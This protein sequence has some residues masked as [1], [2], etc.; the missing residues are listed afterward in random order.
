[1]STLT[2]TNITDALNAGVYFPIPPRTPTPSP[3]D[4]SM[5]V[6]TTAFVTAAI[7]ASAVVGFP[8][9]IGSTSIAGG[10]SHSAFSGLAL[11]NTTIGVTTP[12]AGAF[13]TLSCTSTANLSN[14]SVLSLTTNGLIANGGHV[15]NTSIGDITPA[16]G[17]F[18]T[19]TTSGTVNMT[20]STVTVPT[21]SPGTVS[22]VVASTAFVST[23]IASVSSTFIATAAPPGAVCLFA[24][25]VTTAAP[26]GWLK[27]N[28]ASVLQTDF[29]SLYAV[30]GAMFG[31]NSTHFTIPDLRG[32]F[33]RC[34]DDGLGVDA[35]RTIGSYQGFQL[36]GH[37][38]SFSQWSDFGGANGG[39]A[40]GYSGSYQ[41]TVYTSGAGGTSNGN[42]TRPIN[43]ALLACIKY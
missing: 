40:S 33:L 14:T 17:A 38:H 15:N 12:A 22:T 21:A 19:L 35:G 26:S 31:G 41:G 18:T 34:F 25:Q 1:M 36:T 11:N 32:Q 9:T 4:N 24:M 2:V 13:T 23:A 5:S 20:A 43:V 28:G 42:E 30:I 39:V 8:I 37:N 6:A 27:C 29:P 3:T 10:S 7:A 16:P